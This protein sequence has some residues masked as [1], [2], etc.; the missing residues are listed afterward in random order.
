MACSAG[1]IRLQLLHKSVRICIFKNCRNT[2][3]RMEQ[4]MIVFKSLTNKLLQVFFCFKSRKQQ[5]AYTQREKGGGRRGA[6]QQ[7]EDL[8]TQ[9][10]NKWIELSY[11]VFVLFSRSWFRN[12]GHHQVTVV[13]P[14]HVENVSAVVATSKGRDRLTHDK[15]G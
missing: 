6:C 3:S 7:T 13:W 11:F 8:T 15:I 9:K 5:F 14:T 12:Q 2:L 10:F 4:A 1:V